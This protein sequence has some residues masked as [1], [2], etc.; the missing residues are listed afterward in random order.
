MSDT[1]RNRLLKASS[2]CS[3]L[4]VREGALFQILHLPYNKEKVS[5]QSSPIGANDS[6][7]SA[8]WDKQK[9]KL[10][11]FWLIKIIW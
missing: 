6:Q 2:F 4:W 1:H 7:L 10:L 8:E 5:L 9:D 11:S 3:I